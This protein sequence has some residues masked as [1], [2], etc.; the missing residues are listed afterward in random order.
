MET[1]L[2]TVFSFTLLFI[3]IANRLNTFIRMLA[4]QGL[5]LFGITFLK[6]TEISW[7]NLSMILLETIVFK[8]VAIP[9]F[10]SYIL[11][12]N[13]IVRETEPFVSYFWSL[14]IITGFIIMSYVISGY[15][16]LDKNTKADFT[17]AFASLLTGIYIIITRKKIITHMMGYMILEN[18][19]FLLSLTI[20]AHQ[21]MLVNMGI[22]LDIFVS[23]LVLGLF[24]NRI[25]NTFEEMSIDNLSNLKD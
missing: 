12:K 7:F 13:K 2:L 22:L 1:I 21:P 8:A 19:V 23:V 17:V 10:L 5:L 24:L 9:W 14:I 20:G 4:L 15:L 18:G 16:G 3:G 6:L 25:G 11:H